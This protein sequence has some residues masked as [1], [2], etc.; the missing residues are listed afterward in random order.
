MLLILPGCGN[1]IHV[2]KSEKRITIKPLDSRG[3]SFNWLNYKIDFNRE[4]TLQLQHLAAS[5]DS[6]H[7]RLWN[8]RGSVVDIWSKNGSS[9]YGIVTS[10]IDTDDDASYDGYP[11]VTH[12][13]KD[14]LNSSVAKQVFNIW[15]S[16][17]FADSAIL[18]EWSYSFDRIVFR[19]E[20]SS[21]SVYTSIRF[22]S[23]A[24]QRS[25]GAY[26]L[27][28][29][30]RQIDSMLSLQQRFGRL[31]DSL[32]PGRYAASRGYLGCFLKPDNTRLKE[33]KETY[34][35]HKAYVLNRLHDSSYYYG[36]N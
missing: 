27:I 26:S 11:I 25:K 15:N 17:V 5:K 18:K 6:I 14:T 8:D 13:L 21:P 36:K 12:F 7:M 2:G 28:M 35:Q 29:E 19:S 34:A 22:W 3:Q 31:Y 4:K 23:P 30:I 33:V 1:E 20:W 32:P 10:Y 16:G 9:F 24:S